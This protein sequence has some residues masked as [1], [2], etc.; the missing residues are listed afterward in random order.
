MQMRRIKGMNILS[1]KRVRAF[2]RYLI[3]SLL[4]ILIGF[5]IFWMVTSS[6]K[7]VAEIISAPFRWLPSEIRFEN[8][9]EAWNSA[10]FNRFLVNSIIFTFFTTMGNL[11][12]ASMAGYGFTKF[13]WRGRD[14]SFVLVMATLMLPVE[15]IMV[16]LFI[17]VKN[18]GW[19][20]SYVG[21]IV[22]VMVDAFAIF[23][24]RQFIESIPDDY[25][26]SARMDG[27]SE[28]QIFFRIV[29]PLSAPALA[30]LGMI[31]AMANWDQILWP[32]IVTSKEE[33]QVLTI[34]VS[35]LQSN[36]QNPVNW[37]IALAV[38]LSIP[39]ILVLLFAQRKVMEMSALSG[40]K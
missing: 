40:I 5:P 29:L 26:D 12:I 6:V 3:V 23:F 21:L 24:M 15:V 32:L 1:P 18:L 14:A 20:N 4:A 38:V 28:L 33:L 36:L 9:L 35:R 27:A 25:I 31:K 22:P 8:Y 10:P 30:G 17:I 2:N 19:I 11:L 34:G 13:R 37:R 16:P 7:P 39:M